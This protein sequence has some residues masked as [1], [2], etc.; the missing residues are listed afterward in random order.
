VHEYPIAKHIVEIAQKAALEQGAHSVSRI[1]LVVGDATGYL[2]DCIKLYFDLIAAGSICEGAEIEIERVKAKLRCET[3]GQLFERKPF[4]FDCPC[5]GQ[6]L[7]TGIGQEFYV[8][9]IEVEE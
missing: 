4:S 2:A 7:P 3:C 1:M 9:A 5:G 6:G 8:K